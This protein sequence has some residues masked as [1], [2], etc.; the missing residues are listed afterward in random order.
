MEIKFDVSPETWQRFEQIS[1]DIGKD[2]NEVFAELVQKTHAEFQKQKQ[3]TK[4]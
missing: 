1:G 4:V 3:K 2:R